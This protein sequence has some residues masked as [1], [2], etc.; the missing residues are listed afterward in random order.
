MITEAPST[1][2]SWKVLLIGG[3]SGVGKSTAA[4][5]IAQ[6][7]G[8][9]WLQ[10]DDIRLALQFNPVI[11]S[12]RNPTSPLRFF[13]DTPDVWSLPVGQLRDAFM[14]VAEV[15]APSLRIIIAN[16][17]AIDEPIVIE[18]D[19]VLPSL[20]DDPEMQAFAQAGLLR[21]AFVIPT[22]PDLIHGNSQARGRGL[23][24]GIDTTDN[25]QAVA[26]WTY[27]QWLRAEAEH[28]GIPVLEPE[29]YAT[30]AD[31]I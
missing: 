9:T 27:G 26:N 14:A 30:L 5:A 8:A 29:P 6:R 1:S 4:R 24:S 11:E 16:H 28:R 13:L 7:R 18:G 3:P 15:L 31:R 19:G 10:I 25:R 23:T 22:S 21:P 12:N 17:I 2:R 20:L